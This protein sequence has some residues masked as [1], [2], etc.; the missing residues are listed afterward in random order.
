[1]LGSLQILHTT[2]TKTVILGSEHGSITA[3]IGKFVCSFGALTIWH[4][5][6]NDQA[7]CDLSASQPVRAETQ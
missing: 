1:M 2:L 3:S 7:E 6:W 5:S 4:I